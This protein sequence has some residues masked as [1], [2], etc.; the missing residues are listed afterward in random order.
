MNTYMAEVDCYRR[1][2]HDRTVKVRRT[3]LVEAESIQDVP[4][5]A[6]RVA[7]ETANGQP[8]VDFVCME[9]VRVARFPIELCRTRRGWKSLLVF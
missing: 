2:G 3:F 6:E 5:L 4:K 7:E 9:S 1:E 8:W